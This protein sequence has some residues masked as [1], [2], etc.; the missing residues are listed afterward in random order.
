MVC[1]RR[2]QYR[3][4]LK[5]RLLSS[6]SNHLHVVAYEP[7]HDI[8][9]WRGTWVGTLPSLGGSAVVLW[10]RGEAQFPPSSPILAVLSCPVL[11]KDQGPQAVC[12]SS[13]RALTPM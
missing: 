13:S 6:C 3:P 2:T 12:S 1:P 4:K 9:R 5:S 10:L 11:P 8:G 7:E